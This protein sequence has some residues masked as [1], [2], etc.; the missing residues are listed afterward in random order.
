MVLHIGMFLDRYPEEL[1]GGTAVE[2]ERGCALAKNA[3]RMGLDEP[4]L[5][6]DYKPREG[7]AERT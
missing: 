2:R 7:P 3:Q 4:R 5:N 6:L 1:L